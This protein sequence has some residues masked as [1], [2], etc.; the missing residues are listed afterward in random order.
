[1]PQRRT[2]AWRWLLPWLLGATVAH[3][4]GAPE[5][6]NWFGDPFFQVSSGLSA[7]PVPEG[8]LLTREEAREAEHWRAERGTSC[9]L[10]GQCREPNAY[11]YDKGLAKPV[12]KALAAVPG[13]QAD[14][15]WVTIQRRWV[16]LQGCVR[17][18]AQA[19]ALQRA[20]QAVPDVDA[21]VP[22]LLVGAKGRP[23]YDVR[24]P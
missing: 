15:V 10:H 19:G 12:A 23:P 4:Q 3:A 22:Q 13:V 7:C 11:L 5:K 8:P 14:S 24:R 16:F 2:A 1:V 20:A 17:T 18:K 6:Q 21:V 9:Y